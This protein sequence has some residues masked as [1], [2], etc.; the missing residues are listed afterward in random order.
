MPSL[1]ALQNTTLQRACLC[2]R[3]L[4]HLHQCLQW[5]R[6]FLAMKVLRWNG[7]PSNMLRGPPQVPVGNAIITSHEEDA[8]QE[9][10]ELLKAHLIAELLVG[11][12][13]DNID[14]PLFRKEHTEDLKLI[15][16]SCHVPLVSP[17]LPGK[18]LKV[19]GIKTAICW[20]L[21]CTAIRRRGFLRRRYILGRWLIFII[22]LYPLPPEFVDILPRCSAR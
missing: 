21:S 13:D 16:F 17:E 14:E 20:F 8:S 1:G 15:V 9:D 2:P 22:N 19:A 12:G 10:I 7:A 6:T 4:V 5:S 18:V 11:H 3:S